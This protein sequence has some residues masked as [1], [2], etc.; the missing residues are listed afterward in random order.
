MKDYI[1]RTVTEI[2]KVISKVTCNGCGKDMTYPDPI[3]TEHGC[4]RGVSFMVAFGYGS[5]HDGEQVEVDLCDECVDKWLK[6]M[7]NP[8]PFIPY[9]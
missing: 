8:P 1:E 9:M 3:G 7:V 4:V 5:E 2:Q 6:S